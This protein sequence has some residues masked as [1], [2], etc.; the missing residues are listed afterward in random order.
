[1]E[2]VG[3]GKVSLKSAHHRYLT[4]EDNGTLLNNQEKVG[5]WYAHRLRWGGE[6]VLDLANIRN[7][8]QGAMDV[9]LFRRRQVELEIDAW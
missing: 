3:P 2:V 9:T 4:A 1:M 7:I 8:Q 6:G 5:K